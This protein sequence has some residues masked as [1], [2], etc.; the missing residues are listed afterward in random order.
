MAVEDDMRGTTPFSRSRAATDSRTSADASDSE[1]TTSHPIC[2]KVPASTRA[3]RPVQQPPAT[4]ADAA[5]HAAEDALKS[6]VPAVQIA[7][8]KAGRVV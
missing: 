5:R 1:V 8:S 6:G 4:I 7:V 2:A 3:A